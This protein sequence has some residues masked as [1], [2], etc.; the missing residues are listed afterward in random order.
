M[1]SESQ[2]PAAAVVG[3]SGS[4]SDALEEVTIDVQQIDAQEP[5]DRPTSSLMLQMEQEQETQKQ[6]VTDNDEQQECKD[7]L[8]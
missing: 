4:S 8:R 7:Q 2:V 5:Q 6:S 3:S 1:P